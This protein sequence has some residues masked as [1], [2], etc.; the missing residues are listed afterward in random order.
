MNP[1]FTH[2][3]TKA[4]IQQY[5]S[6]K[7]Y[8]SMHYSPAQVELLTVMAKGPLASK[9]HAELQSVKEAGFQLDEFHRRL[10]T[11]SAPVDPAEK[12]AHK[13]AA[14]ERANQ[15]AQALGN[16]VARVYTQPRGTVQTMLGAAC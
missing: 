15:R 8:S 1:A 6:C 3:I 11:M 10:F 16:R 7:V 5:T 12:R 4:R 14:R 13:K 9:L 2:G